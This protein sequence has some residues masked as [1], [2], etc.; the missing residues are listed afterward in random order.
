[1]PPSTNQAT[2]ESHEAKSPR[3]QQIGCVGYLNAKPLIEGLEGQADTVVRLDVPSALL[4]DLEQGEVDIALCPV[5]DYYR[6]SQ[7][8]IIVPVGCIAS[9]G[10]T[11]TVRLFSKT[12][13]E[14]ITQVHADT[15]SHTSI[16]L[17][18]VVL[19]KSYGITPEVTAFDARRELED[20]GQMPQTMLLIGD[21]VV[22]SAP[23][24]ET[25]PYQLD[26]GEAWKKLTGLP[27]V[28]AVWMAKKESGLGDLPDRLDRVRQVNARQIDLIADRHAESHGWDVQQARTY[29]GKV[30]SYRVGEEHLRAITRFAQEAVELRLIEAAK[31]IELWRT[32]S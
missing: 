13:V 11:H 14:S 9:D 7:P 22:H 29:L 31:P 12:P 18:R 30:L 5:I 1:M 32:E 16:A 6:S 15:D 2:P 28:F 21:K 25:Y 27:F 20:H 19:K 4:D 24:S 8:L 26:L 17:L 10:P 23:S 3:V